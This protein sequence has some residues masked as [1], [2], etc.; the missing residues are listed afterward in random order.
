M[1]SR[2]PWWLLVLCACGAAEE[3][4]ISSPRNSS[5]C[6]PANKSGCLGDGT[7][8][9]PAGL[10]CFYERASGRQSAQFTCGGACKTYSTK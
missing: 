1:V 10:A 5:E 2:A 4:W 8:P 6:P 9:C 3:P 7:A